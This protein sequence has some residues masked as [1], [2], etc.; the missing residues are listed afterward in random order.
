[1]AKFIDAR[2][3]AGGNKGLSEGE[4]EEALDAALGLF[5]LINVSRA[6]GL[7]GEGGGNDGEAG[8]RSKGLSEG[9]GEEALDAALGLFRLINVR[10][11]LVMV[12]GY[13]RPA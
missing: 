3:R 9:E 8:R 10:R 11:G 2:L 1:M 5:R 7:G 13:E 4:L 6:T 12:G